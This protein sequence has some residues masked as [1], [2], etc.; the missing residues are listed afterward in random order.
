[1]TQ[2]AIARFIGGVGVGAASML[3]P[4]YIT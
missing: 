2:F 4:L 3:A 1:M